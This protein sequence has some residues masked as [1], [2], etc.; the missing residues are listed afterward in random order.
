MD[1]LKGSVI[2]YSRI[3]CSDSLRAKNLLASLAMPYLDISLDAFPKVEEQLFDLIGTTVQTPQIFF[4][5]VRVSGYKEL[6]RLV[7]P[8]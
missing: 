8:L 1:E 2:V 5:H 3:G 4:N 7:S 6:R